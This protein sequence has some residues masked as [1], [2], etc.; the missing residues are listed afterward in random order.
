MTTRRVVTGTNREGKS[1]FVHDGPT[2]GHLDLGLAI[3]DEIW[4]DDPENPDPSGSKDPAQAEK[5]HLEPPPDGSILRVFTF[6]PQSRCPTI[7][8]RWRR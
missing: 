5:F 2:P 7:R 8:A 6:Q 1:Y 4:L 3:D